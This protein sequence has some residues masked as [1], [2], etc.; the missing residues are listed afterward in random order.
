LVGAA[1]HAT[2]AEVQ[3]YTK[4]ADKKPERAGR[5]TFRDELAEVLAKHHVAIGVSVPEVVP[6]GTGNLAKCWSE[7]QD[8]ASGLI[9]IEIARVFHTGRAAC[10]LRLCTPIKLRMAPA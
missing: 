4:A 1:G 8:W 10:V 9:V 5:I 3:R 2:L 7:W 6:D